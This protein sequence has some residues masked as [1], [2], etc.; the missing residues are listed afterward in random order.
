MAGHE[1]QPSEPTAAPTEGFNSTDVAQVLCRENGWS[2]D[3]ILEA[4]KVSVEFKSQ[5]MPESSLEQVGEWLVKA[6]FDHLAAKGDFAGNPLTFF[7]QAKYPNSK[8]FQERES[9]R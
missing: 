2:G 6:F 3:K 9:H 1:D 8:S 4:F 5:E 7:Q